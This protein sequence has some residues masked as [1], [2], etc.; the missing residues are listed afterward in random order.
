[1]GDQYTWANWTLIHTDEYSVYLYNGYTAFRVHSNF[2]QWYVDFVMDGRGGRLY[3]NGNQAMIPTRV[4]AELRATYRPDSAP[5]I[6][7]QPILSRPGGMA[8]EVGWLKFKSSKAGEL[9]VVRDVS[10]CEM[11]NECVC[12]PDYM[13]TYPMY[14]MK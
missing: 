13:Y 5:T 7:S 11:Y 14:S 2:S 8:L 4:M 3:P 1:V 12:T 9:T 6:P 10:T